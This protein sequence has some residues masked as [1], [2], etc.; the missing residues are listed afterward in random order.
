MPLHTCF[1]PLCKPVEFCSRLNEELHLHL[2]KLTHT[3]DELTCNNLVAECLSYLCDT[4]RKLHSPRLL[5]IQVVDENAL[6]RLGTKIYLACTL[7]SS[8]HLCREHQVELTYV[9]PVTSTA[10]RTYN[11][12]VQDN[13]L[14]A[15]QVNAAL[16]IHHLLETMVQSIIFLL[17]L[18]N[19]GI[20][21]TELSL[22][23]R[24]AEFFPGLVNFLLNLILVLGHLILNE[25]IGTIALLAV[26]V[27]YK[28]IIECIHVTT[29]LPGCRVHEDS[30]VN[31]NDILVQQDH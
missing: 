24:V 12:L 13:L 29:G 14:H 20:S 7:G 26:T 31:T 30:S 6:C 2:F 9:C 4:K 10:D 8:T 3:E 28:R 16:G 18:K 17:V 15:L 23:K 1:L 21:C 19:T 5:Y 27:V 22:V 25:D 11:F